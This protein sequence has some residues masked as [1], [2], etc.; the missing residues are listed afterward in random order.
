MTHLEDDF[1]DDDLDGFPIREITEEE[2]DTFFTVLEDGEV[3]D[4]DEDEGGID[5][6][7]ADEDGGFEDWDEEDVYIQ[8]DEDDFGVPVDELDD[9]TF[10]DRFTQTYEDLKSMGF[11]D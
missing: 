8:Y 10:M 11:V 2:L 9:A 3:W 7:W 4:D 1:L 6:G 5:D